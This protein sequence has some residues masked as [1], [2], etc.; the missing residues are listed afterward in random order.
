ML[1]MFK[2]VIYILNKYKTYSF[3]NLFKK[4]TEARTEISEFVILSWIVL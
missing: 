4:H 2:N 1:I 3:C